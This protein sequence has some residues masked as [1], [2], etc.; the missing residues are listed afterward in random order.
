MK[1]VL[2]SRLG[3]ATEALEAHLDFHLAAGVDVVVVE[4]DSPVTVADRFARDGAVEVV[5]GSAAAA[6]AATAS[7]ADWLIESDV[8]EFWWPR[9]GSLKELLDPVSPRY[10]SVQAMSRHFARVADGTGPFSERMIHRLV[11]GST[12]R[13]FVGRPAGAKG[14][15]DL[16]RGWVPIEVL[17]FPVS[18]GPGGVYDEDALRRGLEEGVL[19]VDTRI[20]DALRA[21][22]DGCLPDFARVDLF[23]E[24]QFAADLATLGEADV[25]R[26]RDRMDELEARLALLESS[27]SEVMKRKLRKLRT[28]L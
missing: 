6:T 25:A 1:L 14:R 9:G 4:S 19:T 24:A 8:N 18:D 28:W 23:E 17:C 11:H 20:R 27:F 16:V 12:E 22:A 7:G 26:A 5:R 2:A 3:T 15:L 21:L 10:G 13:R